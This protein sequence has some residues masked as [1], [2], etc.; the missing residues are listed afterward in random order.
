[1]GRSNHVAVASAP[2]P[3]AT[4]GVVART[5][6]TGR[7]VGVARAVGEAAVI[8]G[9]L[10]GGFGV[11]SFVGD[12]LPH[13]VY[14]HTRCGDGWISYS[15]GPGTCSHHLGVSEYVYAEHTPPPNGWSSVR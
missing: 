8:I 9:L 10:A 12:H 7:A 5:G 14:S 4:E 6:T 1:M 13:S 2:V 15:Q 11:A 3:V